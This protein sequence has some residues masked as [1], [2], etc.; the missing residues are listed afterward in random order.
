MVTGT[1]GVLLQASRKGLVEFDRVV[2]DLQNTAF[3]CSPALIAEIRRRAAGCNSAI[4]ASSVR[5]RF[6]DMV[7]HQYRPVLQTPL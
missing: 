3:R 4:P 7:D 6:F 1:L 5:R 2:E